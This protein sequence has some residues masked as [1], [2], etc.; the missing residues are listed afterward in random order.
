MQ[1]S[2]FAVQQQIT[3]SG[4]ID[5]S[6]RVAFNPFVQFSSAPVVPPSPGGPYSI[7]LKDASGQVLSMTSFQPV[8]DNPDSDRA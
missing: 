7:E 8:S 6:E 4:T 5:A 2:P 3:L 1:L